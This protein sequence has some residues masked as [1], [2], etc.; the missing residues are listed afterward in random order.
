MESLNEKPQFKKFVPSLSNEMVIN[1]LFKL[2]E[3]G[4]DVRNAFASTKLNVYRICIDPNRIIE[5]KNIHE[6]YWN[7]ESLKDFSVVY[8]GKAST[9][10]SFLE[11]LRLAFGAF[12][13]DIKIIPTNKT[14]RFKKSEPFSNKTKLIEII[15]GRLIKSICD[16]YFES[17]SLSNLIHF[18]HLGLK[19]SSDVKCLSSQIMKED[20]RISLKMI[21]DFNIEMTISMELRLVPIEDKLHRRFFILSDNSVIII[22]CSLNDLDK[23]EVII[24]N[25]DSVARKK[26]ID[27][28]E[29]KWQKA[30]PLI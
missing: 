19:L 27:Y 16:P 29:S 1:E 8:Q 23:D 11:A 14:E 9:Q 2:Q 30:I 17:K 28:F 7:I 5:I 6:T 21:N 12:N 10:T 4:W 22:G 3:L 13:L 25:E 24:E 26:D 18:S 15:N 20:K